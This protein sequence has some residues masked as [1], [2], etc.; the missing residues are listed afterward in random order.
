[1]DERRDA[2]FS[3]LRVAVLDVRRLR[4]EQASE[5]EKLR[6][7]EQYWT[8]TK[9]IEMSMEALIALHAF[10][11]DDARQFA[12]AWRAA[13]E[14]DDLDLMRQLVTAA[15]REWLILQP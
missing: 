10:G 3:A 15:G 5:A 14:T 1:M 4:Y 6:E 7:V 8:K 13:T 2:Y 9:R 12:E 11:S